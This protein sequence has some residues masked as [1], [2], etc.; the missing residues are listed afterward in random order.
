MDTSSKSSSNSS[1]YSALL[2]TVSELRNDLERSMNKMNALESQNQQLQESYHVVKDELVETRRKYNDAQ[3]NYMSTVAAKFDMERQNESFMEMLKL[4]LAEKTKEFEA[5]RDK[6]APQD[7][8]FIRIKIQEELEIPH[9]QKLQSLN[10]ELEIQQDNYNAAHREAERIKSEYEVYAENQQRE[11][12]QLQ[13]EHENAI[14]S[15]RST[16]TVLEERQ[17]NHDKDEQIRQHKY[18]LQEVEH[19]IEGLRAEMKSMQTERDDS[20]TSFEKEKVKY[21]QTIV[22]FRSKLAISDSEKNA[23][24]QRVTNLNLDLDNKDALLRSSRK[25]VEDQSV[26]IELLTQQQ[27]DLQ[28]KLSHIKEDQQAQLQGISAEHELVLREYAG[29]VEELNTKLMD[30]E[31]MIR[32]AQRETAEFQLRSER[33]ENDLRKENNVQLTDCKQQIHSLELEIMDLKNQSRNSQDNFNHMNSQNELELERLRNEN[34]RIVREKEML[35]GKFRENE[36]RLENIRKK[37]LESKKSLNEKLYNS[38]QELGRAQSQIK[39]HMDSLDALTSKNAELDRQCRKTEERCQLLQ[40]EHN[41]HTENLNKQ[42]QGKFD[43]LASSY[44]DKL[45]SVQDKYRSAIEKERK[46]S[47][48]YKAKAIEA[49]NMNKILSSN[50][51]TMQAMAEL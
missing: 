43:A 40:S 29:Q 22:E 3:E 20:L 13:H 12:L 15:L 37:E 49:H 17:Y 34:A 39:T 27:A 41:H 5:V 4:Q 36:V 19:T 24:M 14:T 42:F 25:A 26:R 45:I 21:E 31:D 8:D 51:E 2:A 30:R 7:I 50:I 6:F 35:L 1:H 44:K 9:R 16:I 38:Q 33:R 48:A 28:T 47:E 11:I 46:K 32:K 10:N 23:F 18:K